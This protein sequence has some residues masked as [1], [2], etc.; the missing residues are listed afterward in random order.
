V[1][2][3]AK[4]RAQAADLLRSLEQGSSAGVVFIGA[5]PRAVLPALSRNLS[6][7]HEEL[8]KAEATAERG[9][10][11]AALALAERMLE[12]QGTVYVFSDFQRTNWA[13]VDFARYK[14]LAFYLRPVVKGGVENVGIT[15][16]EK[17]PGEPIE[18]ETLELSCT[19]FNSTAQK[20]METVH[21]DLRD[22]TQLAEV[23]LQ[24]FSS[25][26]A[27][28]SFSLPK[29][30]CYPGKVT[31]RGD[32][33][34]DDNTRYFKVRVRRALKVLV[35]SD[36]DRE[37]TT[38]GAFFVAAA[39]APSPYAATGMQILRRMSQEVDRGA[40]ETADAFFI[41]SPARL[42]G[43]TADIIARRVTDGAVLVCFLDGPTAPG[44]LGALGGSSKGAISP[45][46]Q[47][48]RAISIER[49]TGDSF[50]SIETSRGPLRLFHS[51][52]EGD[53]RSLVFRRRWLTEN[54]SSRRDEI[55]V[56]FADGSAALSLSPAGRGL[57]VFA[58]FPTAPDGASIA[59][60]PLFPPILHELMR[61]LRRT[62]ETDVNTPG[63]DWYI[64]VVSEEE[65]AAA[66]KN[67]TVWGPDGKPIEV[68]VVSRGR[69]AR[70]ALPAARLAGHYLVRL[71]DSQCDA[72]VV[73]VHPDET[74]TRPMTVGEFVEERGS[75]KTTVAVVND[76]GDVLSA[77]KAKAL[78]P[79]LVALAG[80][81]F[82]TE[83]FLLALW[84]RLP[85]RRVETPQRG[86]SQA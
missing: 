85:Q 21:L 66:G 83:M 51:P 61:A 43:E 56:R 32:D 36:T 23:E 58:N 6:A 39:L 8:A 69:T 49:A 64:D 84:R 62:T 63:K 65:P 72:G 59:G 7:L 1:S 15:A 55:L 75:E 57:A 50:G 68:A 76:E 31:L 12:G 40:L 29:A 18:G 22:V 52:Q 3:F 54:V 27:T 78:W 70:L 24:P 82:A 33:L 14:G 45:P 26:T 47:L 37:D 79:H 46:F 5:K 77:G 60:S 53:M 86:R 4:A 41:V 73:N 81:F 34:N 48:V 9:E 42:G 10:P 17:S 25:G 38:G 80:L 13:A 74:D 35:I 30:G 16:I 71:G 20:R 11:A 28:F 2:L 19:V 67:Y 44:I